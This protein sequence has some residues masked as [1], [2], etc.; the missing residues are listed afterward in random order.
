MLLQ[1]D[2]QT[3]FDALF[4][5]GVIDP[6][7]QMDW[8]SALLEISRDPRRLER[9]IEAVNRCEP[10]IDRPERIRDELTRFDA[11]TLEYLAMEVAREY[12]DYHG[13][14]GLH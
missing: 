1:G 12:A 7:L 14:T 4:E 10:S 13:R 8:A 11:Q 5:M 6:V 9:A 2:L 3:V